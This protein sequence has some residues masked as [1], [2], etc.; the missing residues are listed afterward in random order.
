MTFDIAS[1]LQTVEPSNVPVKRKFPKEPFALQ[2]CLAHSDFWWRTMNIKENLIFI[3][4]RNS[5]EKDACSK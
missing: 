4:Q 5:R 2:V 1:V 3:F